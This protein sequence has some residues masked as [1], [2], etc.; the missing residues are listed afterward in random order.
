MENLKIVLADEA[1]VDFLLDI[2]ND[3]FVNLVALQG[4]ESS[5]LKNDIKNTLKIFKEKGDEIFIIKQGEENVGM[6]MLYDIDYYNKNSRIGLALHK[7]YRDMGIGGKALEMIYK[8]AAKEMNMIKVY[9]E[10]Y[11]M[12]SRCKKMLDKC[13]FV[14][15]GELKK[16]K[17]LKDTFINVS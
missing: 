6:G 8:H 1:D 13:G 15:E 4:G 10:V 17:R 14:C 2:Y 16:H 5:I 12:N 9:G 7:N 3:D 11:E